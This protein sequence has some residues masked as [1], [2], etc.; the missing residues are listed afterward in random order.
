MTIK[1]KKRPYLVWK[2]GDKDYKLILKTAGVC[3]AER[4]L[5]GVNL[6]NF[7]G[8]DRGLPTLSDML[9]ITHCSLI[10]N[11][12]DLTLSDVYDI[13]DAYLDEGGSM[14]DFYTQTFM[15]IYKVS[16]FLSQ[17][18]DKALGELIEI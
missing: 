4:K 6:I 13:Y 7:L 3:D 10:A 8:S 12:Q 17:A 14:M 18:Q 16:G 2:V 9:T 15:D 1:A 5:N 11:H